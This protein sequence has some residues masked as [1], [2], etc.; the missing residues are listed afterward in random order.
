MSS[1][2]VRGFGVSVDGHAAGP[3]QDGFENIGA[4]I[5]GRHMFA[6]HL[7]IIRSDGAAAPGAGT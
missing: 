6:N 1:L 2:K 4:W 7:S 3:D 5:I